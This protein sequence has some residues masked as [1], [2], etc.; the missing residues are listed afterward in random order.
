MIRAVV[1][2]IIKDGRIL[3]HYKKRGHGAGK[4]NGLGGKIKDGEEPEECAIREAKEESGIVLK[5]F[6]RLGEIE[7]Y[8][9][10]GE[11]WLVYVFRSDF[12]GTPRESEESLPHW[13][14]LKNIPYEQ[15]WEDDKYWLPLVIHGLY[16]RAR[17]WF[18][19]EE[20]QR[21]IMESWKL[22]HGGDFAH[23]SL[24]NPAQEQ[25]HQSL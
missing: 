15:M 20:M 13:F 16:F 12:E 23:E 3:L 9:V 1:V 10:N 22:T 2:H 24:R 25:K 5:H 7:F 21:F 11:N 19:G 18:H 14:S 6:Q 17:F 4:W 8:D